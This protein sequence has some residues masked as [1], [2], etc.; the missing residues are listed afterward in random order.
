MTCFKE[1]KGVKEIDMKNIANIEGIIDEIDALLKK[2]G[3]GIDE[4]MLGSKDT[5]SLTIIPVILRKPKRVMRRTYAVRWIQDVLVAD[6]DE[7]IIDFNSMFIKRPEDSRYI[8]GS[9]RN[10]DSKY[11]GIYLEDLILVGC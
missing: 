6:A 2:H 9:P 11:I 3:L 10:D 7:M 4:Y 1:N 5:M 8:K